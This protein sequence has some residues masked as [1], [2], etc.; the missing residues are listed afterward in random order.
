LILGDGVSLFLFVLQKKLST[1]CFGREPGYRFDSWDGVSLF[2][3][4]LQL[5]TSHRTGI[6]IAIRDDNGYPL[7]ET[8]WIFALLA[9]EFGSISLPMGLLMGS[10]GNPTGTWA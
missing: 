7:S 9:Y 3:F 1:F 5:S 6:E 4:V 8:R 2:L 10:N